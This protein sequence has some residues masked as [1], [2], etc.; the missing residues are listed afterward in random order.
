MGK[1]ALADYV[2]GWR[3]RAARRLH[4]DAAHQAR[5]RERLVEVV[6]V[7]V[8]DYGAT[9]IVLFGSLARGEATQRSDV[10]LLVSGVPPARMIAATVAVSQAR[11]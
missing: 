10:D 7:L 2:V 8:D 6:R 1:D 11:S 4:D 3:A 5:L 9:R